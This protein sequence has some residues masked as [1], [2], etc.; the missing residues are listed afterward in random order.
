MRDTAKRHDF[1]NLVYRCCLISVER[2]RPQSNGRGRLCVGNRANALASRPDAG[3]ECVKLTRLPLVAYLGA[4]P[5]RT[6]EL[7]A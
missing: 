4:V 2:S 5:R 3:N 6:F 1:D 7:I